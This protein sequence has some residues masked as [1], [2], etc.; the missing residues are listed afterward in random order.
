MIQFRLFS[1]EK[2]KISKVVRYAEDFDGGRKYDNE[3]HFCRC[4]VMQLL[5]KEYDKIK[6]SRGR[7]LN[8]RTNGGK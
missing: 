1:E 3:S 5:L 6:R 8:Q 4:A 7:P 2:A